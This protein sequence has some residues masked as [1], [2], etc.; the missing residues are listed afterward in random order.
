MNGVGGAKGMK[1]RQ[2]TRRFS[3]HV[4]E[5]HDLQLMPPVVQTTNCR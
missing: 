5:F 4:V 1:A 3:H 2:L